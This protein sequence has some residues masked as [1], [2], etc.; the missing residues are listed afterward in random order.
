[1]ILDFGKYKGKNIKDVY[2]EDPRYCGWLKTQPMVQENE[3]IMDFLDSIEVNDDYTMNW[4]KYKGKR[5]EQIQLIDN[6]Y[7]GWLK[8]NKYV[9]ENCP[10]LVEE[11][12][13]LKK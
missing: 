12:S 11:L 7:I 10:R 6:K 8:H 9:T 13:K 3:E 2:E 5:L 4:G 1:M